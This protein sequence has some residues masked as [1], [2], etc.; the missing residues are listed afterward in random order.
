MKPEE[1]IPVIV[2]EILL[3]AGTG[4]NRSAVGTGAVDGLTAQ[5]IAWLVAVEGEVTAGVVGASCGAPVEHAASEIAAARAAVANKAR[6]GGLDVMECPLICSV[7]PR[8]GCIAVLRQLHV[9]GVAT[10]PNSGRRRATTQVTA[11][12][13]R[14]A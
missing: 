4:S 14:R 6:R 2:T 1:G 7:V 3:S 11:S 8:A 13:I 9:D 10:D 5:S 12:I